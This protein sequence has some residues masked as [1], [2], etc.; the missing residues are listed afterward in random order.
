MLHNVSIFSNLCSAKSH[1]CHIFHILYKFYFSVHILRIL[2]ICSEI[3]C[4][5]VLI[6]KLMQTLKELCKGCKIP[7][8]QWLPYASDFSPF[9]CHSLCNWCNWPKRKKR[10][11]KKKKK[12]LNQLYDLATNC[13]TFYIMQ[14]LHLNTLLF[15]DCTESALHHFP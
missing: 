15:V 8:L 7:R 5:D 6:L 12:D 9:P 13:Y 1:Y 4:T 10:E 3:L 2:L 14:A 11:V